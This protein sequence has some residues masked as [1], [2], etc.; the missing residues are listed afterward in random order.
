[1]NISISTYQVKEG[2]SVESVA[3]Q[4]GISLEALKRYHNTYCDLKNLIGNDLRGVNEIIIPPSE[5]I[6]ELKEDQKQMF[7]SK[8]LPP[9]HLTEDFYALNY[10][11]TESFDKIDEGDLSI[12][13]SVFV[14]L[15]EQSEKGFVA[16][17]KTFDFKKNG[18]IPDDKISALSLASMESINPIFFSIP[19]QGKIRNI[20]EHK[21]LVKKFEH[22]RSDLEDFFIGETNKSYLDNFHKSIENEGYLFQQFQ[23]ALL[24][25]VLFP[26]MDWLRRKTEWEAEFFIVQNSFPVKCLFHAEFNFENP[27]DVEIFIKGKIN[28]N[29]SLQELLKGTK[30][31]KQPEETMTVDIE[32]HYTT[33][34][35]NKQLKKI[36]ASIILFHQQEIYQKHN[37]ILKSKEEIPIKK[38]S[39]LID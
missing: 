32:L 27:N 8:S 5:K 34:K 6:T 22:T 14:K 1:M 13:Y 17:V 7:L 16:E 33:S 4:L 19:A 25:Q 18:E 21:A 28:E 2:D 15:R 29:F 20:Y 9:L 12:G 35:K 23:S 24:Y 38:F 11:V 3:D 37:L 30:S 31:E 39:T 10:E 36:E 26:E